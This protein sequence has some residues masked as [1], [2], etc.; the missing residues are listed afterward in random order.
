MTNRDRADRLMGEASEILRAIPGALER[1]SWN[2]AVRRSQ[3]VVELVLKAL[4]AEMGVDYPKIHDVGPSFADAVRARGLKI[5][6]KRLG[7]VEEVSGKLAAL[8]APAF[9]FEVDYSE[10]EARAAVTDAEQIMAFATTLLERL[11]GGTE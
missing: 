5:E 2:L 3:E 6:E 10:A 8:R 1:G 4:L 9:Y 7:W 11:R